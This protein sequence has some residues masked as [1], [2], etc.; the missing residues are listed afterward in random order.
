MQHQLTAGSVSFFVT[1]CAQTLTKKLPKPAATVLSVITSRQHG[2]FQSNKSNWVP[3]I[4]NPIKRKC[5]KN[6]P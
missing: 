2:F 1:R 5:N 3:F 4:G 6:I